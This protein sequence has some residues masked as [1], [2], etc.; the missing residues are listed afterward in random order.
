MHFA[1][2]CAQLH[3]CKGEVAMTP[4]ERVLCALRHEKTD[5]TPIDLGSCNV[6]SIN[7]NAYRNLLT[8][9]GL[10][11]GDI[12]IM[13]FAS[14]LV[15]PREELLRELD[16]DTRGVF[17]S[18]PKVSK[19][20]FNGENECTDVWGITY[21]RPIGGLY[22]DVAKSP[23]E[24]CETLE[25]VMDYQFPAIEDIANE[26]GC[27]Q[28]AGEIR[29][30]KEH[31]IVGSFGSSIFM[32]VQEL[33][34]YSQVFEDMLVDKD[35]V[36]YLMDKVLDIR[37]KLAGMLINAYSDVLDV[38]Q[39]ADDVAGQISSL[40]SL[41]SYRELIKPRT[42]KLI[43]FIKKEANVKI[44]YHCCGNVYNMI[45]D[46]V[47]AGVDILNPVQVS[48]A[49]MGDLKRLKRRFGS[50]I[51]FWGGIDCQKLLPSASPEE[52]RRVA[53]QTKDILGENGGYVLSAAHNI[54]AD[55]PAENILAMFLAA[56]EK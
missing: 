29:K 38:V 41:E 15:K 24:K 16:I 25:E 17:L 30:N 33:R 43:E 28:I 11:D 51:C 55:V 22:F 19:T 56:R 21:R 2:A 13:E 45:D 35:I 48:A 36:N 9:L 32:R 18:K 4:R 1:A 53:I 40:V 3:K 26:E 39:I 7:I 50:Q 8:K 12:R 49:E 10:E 6:S 47:E 37:I 27:A 20:V 23:L 42:Q 44:L 52:V 54:Q 46:F 34:G 5:H 14:Q 31:A